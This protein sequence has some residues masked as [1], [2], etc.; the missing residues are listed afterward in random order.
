MVKSGQKQIC[1]GILQYNA[2]KGESSTSKGID[3]RIDSHIVIVRLL[4]SGLYNLHSRVNGHGFGDRG[5]A[6]R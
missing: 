6:V 2:Q 1:K 4:A 5:Q 3:E